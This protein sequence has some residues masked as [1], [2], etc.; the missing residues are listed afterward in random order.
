MSHDSSNA[1]EAA[2]A[3]A[4]ERAGGSERVGRALRAAAAAGR[5]GDRLP[6]N[7]ALVAEHRAGP[8]TVARVVARLVAESVVTTSPGRG[9]FIAPRRERRERDYGWQSVTLGP[10]V[11]DAEPVRNLVST[12][13]V[14][15]QVLSSG[16]LSPDLQPLRELTA[17]ASRA[18][19]RPHAWEPA[20]PAGLPELRRLFAAGAGPDA[21]VDAGD[22][23]VVP[24]GQ[25]GLTTII[26]TLAPAG[27]TV[28]LEE[29]T[30]P[31]AVTATLAAGARAA[32]AP[33]DAGGLRPELLGQALAISG[34]RVVYSQPTFANP[35]GRSLAADRRRQVLDV[36]ADAGAFL[37][38]D[39]WARDLCFDGTAPAPLLAD[40]AH[41][42]V[43]HLRS[44]TKSV[45]PSLRIGAVLSRGPVGQR[46]ADARLADDFFVS[47]MLQE[48][49][50]E[51][52]SSAAWP[53]HLARLRGRLT[54]RRDTLLQ[55]ITEL[56]PELEV[57]HVPQGGLHLWARLPG[58]VDDRERAAVARRA[59]VVVGAGADYHLTRPATSHLRLSFGAAD[60]TGLRSGVRV[61][62]DCLGGP[63]GR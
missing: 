4:A 21:G 53:R 7:R 25:T 43:V 1:S 23:L 13:D 52:L 8:V 22:V 62:A 45:A 18:L 30:Y 37:I 27:S 29:P 46:L 20:D 11:L 19:R 2:F 60:A 24:S 15:L 16:Y 63:P 6:S 33:T 48:A 51:L 3:G 14:D 26:R 9:T 55:A 41:G 56:T 5:P 57:D 35:T 47:R 58:S 36:V 31:G 40:D 12:P 54:Q 28:L 10:Q 61:L 50:I 17:A 32:P 44:L 38:E 49:A 39:D 59:G 42:H 34:A